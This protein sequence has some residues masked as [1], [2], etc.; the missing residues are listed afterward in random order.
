MAITTLS[1]IGKS[2]SVGVRAERGQSREQKKARSKSGLQFTDRSWSGEKLVDVVVTIGAIRSS[3]CGLD[4]GARQ[5]L[6]DG[7]S[8]AISC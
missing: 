8:R 1:R 7:C 4:L 3:R 2:S 6:I 5:C